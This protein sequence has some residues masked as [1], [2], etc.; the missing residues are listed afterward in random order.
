MSLIVNSERRCIFVED[1]QDI[2]LHDYNARRKKKANGKNNRNDQIKA[3]VMIAHV[4]IDEYGTPA[5]SIEKQGVTPYFIYAGVVIEEQ[6]LPKAKEIHKQIIGTYFG[7]TYMKSSNIKND[8]KGHVK[9]MK[10]ISELSK[11]NHY[12]ATLIVDKSGL[13]SGGFEYKRSFLKFFNR[14]FD[15]QFIDNYDEYHL[16]LDKTGY[17][18]FQQSLKEY[19]SKK[20]IWQN[21]I[22]K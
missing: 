15:K 17:P 9:R 22:F 14:F 21:I 7:G 10:I 8:S 19:M 20:R 18:E 6:D 12:I 4:F 2:K 1:Y 13:K 5:L 16:Y 3:R 11:I